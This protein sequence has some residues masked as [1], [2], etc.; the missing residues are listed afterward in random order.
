G[1]SDGLRLLHF[2][3]GSQVPNIITIKNAVVEATRY[4]CQLK[5]MGFPMGYLDVGGGLGIDYDGSRSNYE[6]STNYS[7]EEYARDV[8]YN[9]KHICEAMEVPCPDN[10]S[11]SGR[12]IAAPHS[13]LVTEVFERASKRDSLLTVRQDDI[14][15]QVVAELYDMLRGK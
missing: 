8:V 1:L 6:S 14:K 5:K 4:Y 15:D 13:I 7:L 11:E 10:I 9:V 3:I 2:H 12:A